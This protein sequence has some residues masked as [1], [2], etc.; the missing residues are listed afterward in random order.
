MEKLENKQK[1]GIAMIILLIIGGLIT[2]W[3]LQPKEEEEIVI[4]EPQNTETEIQEEEKIMIHIM[5]EVNNPGVVTLPE[6]A[7]MIDAIEAAGGLTQQADINKIN[8]VYIL[9]DGL[10]IKI[11]AIG[12]DMH[13]TE[14]NG[15]NVI[16]ENEEEEEENT[17][18]NINKAETE[19]LMQL[20]GIGEAMAQRIIEYRKENGNFEK[21]ED[22]QNVS[23][24]GEAKFNKIKANIC[25]K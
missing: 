14:E 19:E 25:V 1:I 6:G 17:M 15:E 3:I 12:E 20:P 22:L 18:I 5:G 7:R 9:E 4:P 8:L 24:I 11:P 21:I 10:K 23:G 13:I 2:Y 16:I